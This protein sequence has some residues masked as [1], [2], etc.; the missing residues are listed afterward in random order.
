MVILLAVQLV[1]RHSLGLLPAMVCRIQNGLMTLMEQFCKKV[2]T[3]RAGKELIFPR[4]GP[5]PRVEMSYAN[6]MAWFALHCPVLIQPEEEPPEGVCFAH[7]RCFENSQ[8]EGKYVTG[9]QRLVE[10]QDSCS[11]FRCFPHIPGTL[12]GKEFR[13]I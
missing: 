6:L 11:L 9:V 8:W 3:T 12:Y 5:S 10:H 13:D 2:T 7:L 4:D 1:H